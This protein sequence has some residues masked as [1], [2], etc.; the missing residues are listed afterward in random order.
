MRS[1]FPWI[2]A[3]YANLGLRETVGPKHNPEV[4]ALWKEG[5]AGTF[6]DD[7]TPW[8]AA[9]VSAKL[10]E[11]GIQSARTGWARGYRK[12]GQPLASPAVGCIVVL[13]RGP[14]SGHVGFVVGRNLAGHLMVLGGNQSNRVSI[15]PFETKRVLDYRWPTGV[16]LPTVTGRASLPLLA[17]SGKP[18][19][20]EA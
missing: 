5:K 3:A 1:T 20:N 2:Q 11:V 12:W 16:A 7:E 6:T 18:S 19:T 14:T 9:F 15:A 4:V 10:E 17:A 13:E 8:C